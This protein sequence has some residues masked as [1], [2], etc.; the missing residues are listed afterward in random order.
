MSRHNDLH[1][2]ARRQN[3][4][5]DELPV[6][7]VTI[8]QKTVQPLNTSV[9]A[10]NNSDS[11][12]RYP[13]VVSHDP[14]GRGHRGRHWAKP[15]RGVVANIV[16]DIDRG[17]VPNNASEYDER[18]M[19]DDSV[20]N[21]IAFKTE[22]RISET[23]P[24]SLE[25]DIGASISNAEHTNKRNASGYMKMTVDTTKAAGQT[26]AISPVVPPKPKRKKPANKVENS[27]TKTGLW[28]NALQELKEKI[29]ERKVEKKP[30][31]GLKNEDRTSGKME[32]AVTTA[33]DISK[34]ELR[35]KQAENADLVVDNLSKVN[36]KLSEDI[37]YYEDTLRDWKGRDKGIQDDSEKII[38][39]RD[40]KIQDLDNK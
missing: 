34:D 10:T 20:P 40:K 25:A 22:E 37:E 9:A 35:T 29:S 6:R 8:Q 13:N 5:P 11:F 12:R 28:E 24:R 17:V 31:A 15:S 26:K 19:S 16:K 30:R 38:G 1:K 2:P 3:S 23:S 4:L 27:V 36:R 14:S 39:E 32:I 18:K 33:S 7:K 21:D